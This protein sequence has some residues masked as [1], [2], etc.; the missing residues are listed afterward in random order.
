[1]GGADAGGTRGLLVIGIGDDGGSRSG[2]RGDRFTLSGGSGAT[3]VEGVFTIGRAKP[4]R[5]LVFL[6][7]LELVTKC[8]P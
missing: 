3:S 7:C 1:M 2:C 6:R 4:T 8:V 5:W